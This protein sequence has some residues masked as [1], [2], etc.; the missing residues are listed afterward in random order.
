MACI[1]G[2]MVASRGAAPA[3]TAQLADPRPLF[4]HNLRLPVS[5]ARPAELGNLPGEVT[6]AVCRMA[7]KSVAGMQMSPASTHQSASVR[8]QRQVTEFKF[9]I[10]L[11]NPKHGTSAFFK[12]HGVFMVDKKIIVNDT[13]TSSIHQCCNVY[14]SNSPGE[15]FTDLFD[16][17]KCHSGDAKVT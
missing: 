11:D 10:N 8:S 5:P 1:W 3:V 13:D 15:K 7:P 4:Y 14:V 9:K 6:V 17:T 16:L 12:R 2:S